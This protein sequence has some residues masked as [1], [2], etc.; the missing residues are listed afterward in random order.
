MGRKPRFDKK[1]FLDAAIEILADGGPG[2]VTMNAVADRVGGPIGSLYHRFP[3]RDHLMAELWITTVEAFQRGFLERLSADDVKGA[4]LYTPQWV[5]KRYSEARALLLHRREDLLTG[6]WPDDMQKRSAV[7]GRELDDGM[8]SFL[9]RRFGRA[10]DEQDTRVR[11]ALIDVPFASVKPYLD[12]G[13]VVPKMIDDLV[14]ETV[15]A[16]LGDK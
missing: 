5:R 11:F 9:T 13:R 2:A 4:A 12:A 10:D 16:V 15:H 1:Q 8:R 7:L 6:D 3:S 14:L